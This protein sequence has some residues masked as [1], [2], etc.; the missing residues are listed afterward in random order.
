M[1]KPVT[2]PLATDKVHFVGEPIAVVVAE[3]R[4]QA[5]DALEAISVEYDALPAVID[6]ESA[7]DN[8]TLVN[9]DIGTNQCYALVSPRSPTRRPRPRPTW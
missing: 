1:K 5:S 4:Y 2:T 7:F 3:T 9:E 6:L 8:A